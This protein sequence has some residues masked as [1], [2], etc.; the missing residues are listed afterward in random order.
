MTI[1]LKNNMPKE[2]KP[3]RLYFKTYLQMIRNSAG[4]GMFR[5]WY[6]KTAEQGEFDAM[7]DGEDSCAFYVSGLLR[8]FNKINFIHGTVE[9][10]IKDLEDF[11]WQKV[12]KANPGDVLVWEALQFGDRTQKHIGFY[13]GEGRAVS[14]SWKQKKVTEHDMNFGDDYRKIEQI[15]RMENWHYDNS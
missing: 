11:G 10:T 15:H 3:T 12:R 5:N 2:V 14:T 1:I 8:I 6:L 4:S 7:R 9:S 13:I